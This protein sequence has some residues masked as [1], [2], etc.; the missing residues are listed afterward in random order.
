VHP[1]VALTG[2][3]RKRGVGTAYPGAIPKVRT[4]TRN[5]LK[6]SGS[7]DIGGIRLTP[8]AEPGPSAANRLG[9]SL[10]PG[11]TRPLKE[12]E[13]LARFPLSTMPSDKINCPSVSGA[14]RCQVKAF[15]AATAN[16]EPLGAMIVV[17]PMCEQARCAPLIGRNDDATTRSVCLGAPCA[18]V[19]TYLLASRHCRGDATISAVASRS[20]AVRA[21][22]P[23]DARST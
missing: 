5:S 20:A 14:K 7:A 21:D 17:E 15:A 6:R 16:H 12:E 8:T 3:R 19:D 13:R 4:S 9:H 1:H 22:R 18:V 23:E 10:L 2:C 11:S